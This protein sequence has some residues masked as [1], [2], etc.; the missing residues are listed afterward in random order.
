MHQACK[1]LCH[2][3]ERPHVGASAQQGLST[4]IELAR[5]GWHRCAA[6]KRS[7]H[8]LSIR[9]I[10]HLVLPVVLTL[11]VVPTR[12]SSQTVGTVGTGPSSILPQCLDP[13]S[14]TFGV[15]PSA[16]ARECTRQYCAQPEYRAKV[17][18]YAR[19]QRQSKANEAGALT[20]IT[21]WEQDQGKK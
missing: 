11:C 4:E 16:R 5:L 17:T 6:D 8:S 20:C 18:V 19:S 2:R 7:S 14:P 9:M 3:P 10:R 12:V 13:G 15:G 21:R 1:P